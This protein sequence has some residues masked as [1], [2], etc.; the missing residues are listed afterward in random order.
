M[1]TIDWSRSQNMGST[2]VAVESAVGVLLYQMGVAAIAL[3]ALLIAV[4]VIL[5]R[6]YLR[7]RD[8]TPAALAL[9]LLTITVNGIFQEEA[10]FS[11]LAL[12][13]MLALCGTALGRDYRRV[14]QDPRLILSRQD[15]AAISGPN[16]L[17]TSAQQHG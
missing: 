4:V 12:G 7:T 6:N 1:T 16:S 13:L 3:L 17:G 15:K 2:D 5:W 10:L 8:R 11:P 9:G 14:Y